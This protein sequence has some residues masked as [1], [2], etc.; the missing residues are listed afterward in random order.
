MRKKIEK[1]YIYT[2]LGF[3]V[4]LHNV[5]M[6]EIDGTLHPK[7]DVR[8][9]AASVIES[10]IT[11]QTRFTGNQVK[12]IRTYFS[13]SLRQFAKVVNE[14]HTA[15]SKWE[16]LAD[17]A[18]NMDVNIE[19]MLRLYICDQVMIQN[20]HKKTE[21]YNRYREVTRIFHQPVGL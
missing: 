8:K 19:S 9:V 20:K 13:M 1:R 2:G 3:P 10:L 6:I 5:E 15:V 4:E 12:F 14:S 11:Q 18:T 16:S 7:I 17:K 21:F